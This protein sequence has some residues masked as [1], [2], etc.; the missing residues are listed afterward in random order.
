MNPDLVVVVVIILLIAFLY[1]IKLGK[2]A[3]VPAEQFSTLADS[4]QQ[5]DLKAYTPPPLEEFSS[6]EEIVKAA[7]AKRRLEYM[8]SSMKNSDDPLEVALGGGSGLNA[9]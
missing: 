9:M 7:L 3:E 4:L 8:S 6:P 2:K 1:Y 5:Q